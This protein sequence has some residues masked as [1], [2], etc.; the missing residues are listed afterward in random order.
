MNKSIYF[1]II[2]VTFCSVYLNYKV[3]NSYVVQTEITRDFNNRDYGQENFVKIQNLDLSYPNIG[4]TALPLYAFLA[5]YQITYKEYYKAIE[6]LNQE[7]NVNP[8]LMVI[9]SLKAEVYSNLGIRDSV[10][11][12]SKI[13]YENLPKNARHFEQ[14]IKVLVQ[15]KDLNSIKKVFRESTIKSNYQYWLIYFA[16]VIKL[17]DNQDDEIAKYA[18]LAITKFPNNDEIKTISAFILFG[19]ENV[20]KSYELFQKGTKEFSNGDF[21]KS[22]AYYI[23]AISLNEMDYSFYENAGMALFKDKKYNESIEYFQ[24]VINNFNPKTGKSEYGLASAYFKLG[25]KQKSCDLYLASMKFD[26]KPAFIDHSKK[27]NK[28]K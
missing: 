23:E 11:Y 4:G 17:K 22:A 7:N 3:Y 14:Y 24:K 20:T 25:E 15:K 6:T 27:C 10:Y 18:R 21:E 5:K 28:Y 26:F 13:A 19:Q 12:Y 2:I 9:E 1:L 8:Y 16:A